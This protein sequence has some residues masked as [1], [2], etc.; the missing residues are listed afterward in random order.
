MHVVLPNLLPGWQ[1]RYRADGLALVPPTG[2]RG[3][4]RIR[5]HLQPLRRAGDALAAIAE[6][7][8]FF[9]PLTL[10]PIEPFVT[11][12]G[13]FA[14][15]A[16]VRGQRGEL[17]FQRTVAWV[18]GDHHYTQIDGG[19][20][21]TAA[22]DRFRQGVRDLAYY[23]ALGLGEARRRR[24]RYTAPAGWRAYTRGLITEWYAPD[25]PR[26]HG[27]ISVFPARPGGD[28]PAAELDRLLHEMSWFGF[29]RD[30]VEG[31]FPVAA[32]DGL[33]GSLWR[34]SGRFAGGP[35]LHFEIAVLE[36]A[37]YR[38]ALRLE[39]RRDHLE[40]HRA[41]FEDV[42]ASVRPLP[43]PETLGHAAELAHWFT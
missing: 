22:F 31:P 36:D 38:Y 26:D 37:R 2:G 35:V 32:V 28:T 18:W 3:G 7:M 34:P 5:E 39:S 9:A 42:V 20:D 6:Q 19:T 15:I 30:A 25:F 29:E 23:H 33:A 17:P 12:E 10:S 41:V 21:D 8:Q 43:R 14:A 24:F 40:R 27:F 11:C 16:Q 13:E 1:V 4:I